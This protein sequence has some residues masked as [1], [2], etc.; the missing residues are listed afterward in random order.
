MTEENPYRFTGAADAVRALPPDDSPG[1]YVRPSGPPILSPREIRRLAFDR[2]G[3]AWALLF[4]V[5]WSVL[6][7]YLAPREFFEAILASPNAS[8]RAATI[9]TFVTHLPAI[10]FAYRMQEFSNRSRLAGSI[11]AA[12]LLMPFVKYLVAFFLLTDSRQI[13]IRHSIRMGWLKTE[14]D[15]LPG[16]S[17][18][19][20]DERFP[21]SGER[22]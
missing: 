19:S 9:V 16:A 15:S 4:A 22:P 14:Q 8:R 21:A 5:A 2:G 20:R 18:S 11:L 7:P 3:F 13:L 12:L 1:S 17:F 6:S 10:Y